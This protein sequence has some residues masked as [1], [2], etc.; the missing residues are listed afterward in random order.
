[1]R[2]VKEGLPIPSGDGEELGGPR[3]TAAVG[4]TRVSFLIEGNEQDW[5]DNLKAAVEQNLPCSNW[6]GRAIAA[7]PP[8]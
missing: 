5:N 2:A 7:C 6:L 8:V 3:S 4:P 1:M